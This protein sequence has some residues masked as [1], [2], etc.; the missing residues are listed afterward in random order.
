MYTVVTLPEF[1]AWLQ[2]IR[3]RRSRQRLVHRLDK[4]QSGNLGDV[5]QVGSGVWEMREHFGPGF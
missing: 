1:D 4:A 2:G 5:R 3:D